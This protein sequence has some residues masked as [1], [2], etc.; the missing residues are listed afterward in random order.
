M[1]TKVEVQKGPI[2]ADHKSYRTKTRAEL[3]REDAEKAKMIVD[4][5]KM[6][7]HTC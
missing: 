7:L 1:A 6:I 5:R 2:V 4:G 3:N